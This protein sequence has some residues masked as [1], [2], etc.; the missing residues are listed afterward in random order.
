VSISVTRSSTGAEELAQRYRDLVDVVVRGGR[1][2]P[3]ALEPSHPAKPEDAVVLGPGHAAVD[4]AL[5]QGGAAHLERVLARNPE[6]FDGAVLALDEVRDGVVH[7]VRASYF[8]MLAT[9]DVL[10]TGDPDGVLREQAE[11]LVDGDPL[12]SGHGRAAAAG[13]TVVVVRTLADGATGFT[14]GRRSDHLPVDPGQWHVV[15][16]GTIDGRGLLGTLAEELRDEHG[17]QDPTP[18]LKD[19]RVIGLGYDLPRLRPEVVVMT[20]HQ[21]DMPRPEPSHEFAEVRDVPLDKESLSALWDELGPDRL[22]AA[23]VVAL[24]AVERELEG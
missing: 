6:T 14:I 18:V 16:S 12:R 4:P 11:R 9:C 10:Q 20:E 3:A 21:G 7:V 17:L 13:S 22:T 15:A 5:R 1:S 23:G 2:Y 19:A 8:D 24:A